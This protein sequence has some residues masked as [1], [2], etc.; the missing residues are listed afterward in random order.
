M[1]SNVPPFFN[2]SYARNIGTDDH[3]WVVKNWIPR[4]G[5]VILASSPKAGKTALASA[6]ARAVAT[7]Q[8]FLGQ[9]VEQGPVMW[10]SYEETPYERHPYVK[11][12]P[13]DIPI[14]TGFPYTLPSLDGRALDFVVDRYGRYSENEEPEIFTAAVSV[15]AK[16]IV[17]DCLHAAV[18]SW[19]LAENG[20]ARRLMGRLRTWSAFYHI[21]VLV[22]HHVTK[23][24][25]RGYYPERFADS[26]QILAAASCHHFMEAFHQPDGTRRI[27]IHSQGRLPS[28]P[29]SQYIRSENVHHFEL[30]EEE[31]EV[32]EATAA[33]RVSDLI[34]EGWELT[35]EEI[36]R[37]LKMPL[38]TVRNSLVTLLANGTLERSGSA[39]T[40]FYYFLPDPKGEP[41]AVAKEG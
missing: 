14:Y 3:P 25:T 28:P 16:L 41:V 27:S 34:S 32:R 13:D 20:A 22:L 23:S 26:S 29:P 8:D 9:P 10:C 39:R 11:D 33:E 12:L 37:K 6:M 40:K 24:A 7:G 19:N 31:I 38:S 30:I 2:L 5:L 35:S 18:R 1:L 15:K 36:A 17:I 4:D 21:A